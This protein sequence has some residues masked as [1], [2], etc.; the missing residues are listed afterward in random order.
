MK[1]LSVLL[2]SLVLMLGLIAMASASCNV[3]VIIF[4][5]GGENLSGTQNITWSWVNASECINTNSTIDYTVNGSQWIYIGNSTLGSTSFIWNTNS[6]TDNST[7]KIRVNSSNN[8]VSSQDNF[9]VDNTNPTISINDDASTT[10]T[11]SDVINV[12][13]DDSLSGIKETKWIISSD[14]TCDSSKDVDLN[15]SS[16]SGTSVVANDEA[17]YSNKFI[18]F[19]T[20][21]NAGNYNYTVSS[22]I[23]KLDTT[24][25]VIYDVVATPADPSNDNTPTITFKVNDT[26]SGV[27][28][29]T[30]SFNDGNNTFNTSDSKLSCSV[31]TNG[32]NCTMQYSTNLSDGNHTFSINAS[33]NVGIS[34][35]QYQIVNYTVDTIA[36]IGTVT[37]GTPNMYDGDLVQ[38]VNV[39]YNETMDNSTIPVI[40]FS[41]TT[42]TFTFN[43]GV[44][45]S[46][47]KTWTGNFTLTDVNETVAVVTVNSSGAKD[48]AGNLEVAGITTNFSVD[49]QNPVVT[50]VNIS[51][52]LITDVDVNGTV[53]VTVVFNETMDNRT[54]PSLSF[55]SSKANSTLTL[56]STSWSVDNKTFIVV[57]NISDA[58]VEVT[59]VNLTVSEA[60][61]IVGNV[62]NTN[63]T[64][65]L[66]DIDT[67]QPKVDS[68]NVI[69]NP[70]KDGNVSINITFSEA[71]NLSINPNVTVTGL[72]S[73]P[74]IVVGS[75][76]NS[77]VWSGSFILN[78]NNED[79]NATITVASAADV[80]GNTM[81]N[82]NSAGLFAVDTIMPE[83]SAVEVSPNPVRVGTS[84]TITAHVIETHFNGSVAM[85]FDDS[86]HNIKNVTTGVL[87]NGLV[88][89]TVNNLA[90]NGTYEVVVLSNDT[91]RNVESEDEN[92]RATF[93]VIP[94]TDGNPISV[95][96]TL[97]KYVVRPGEI[98]SVNCSVVFTN[99]GHYEINGV[100]N[101]NGVM[102]IV[103]A[104][105]NGSHVVTCKAIDDVNNRFVIQ[106]TSYSV[107]ANNTATGANL[108][109][110][111]ATYGIV[112]IN[113]VKVALDWLYHN[114]NNYYN[115]TQIDEKFSHYYTKSDVYN[116]TESNT[117]FV[118]RNSWTDIDNYPTACANGEY[119]RA[120][121]DTL[122]CVADNDTTYTAGTGLVLTTT[123]FSLDTT[124]TNVLYYL[125][126][127]VDA[128]V[129]SLN[130]SIISETNARTSNDTAL[131]NQITSLENR[132]VDDVPGIQL[133]FTRGWNEFHIPS[134]VLTGTGGVANVSALNL[135]NNY[136]VE[137]VL[138]DINGSYTYISYYDGSNWK[139]YE[140]NG[141]KTFTE[142]PHA[143]NTPDYAYYIYMTS[144][145]TATI[146][147][148]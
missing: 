138:S 79:L 13:V 96:L 51:D 64:S 134:F 110:Y 46:T 130:A 39:T 106:N 140:V 18:C 53:E 115:I 119:V 123:T 48:L 111:I 45:D 16:N 75:F 145:A 12:S 85:I 8:V 30:I 50:S 109:T 147:L 54:N 41:G 29:S 10:W 88:T 71:M 98:I 15:S 9:T 113:N 52:T 36:P 124:Y 24:E 47:N 17:T 80:A 23:Q 114:F 14:A 103:A 62:L 32:Y 142:F 19:R 141:T 74:Y 137:N 56:F 127:Q 38:E 84:F 128:K 82:N 91:A 49:T 11:N 87:S 102:D 148:E 126:S 78:D 125:K 28:N 59:G 131:Q 121:G 73:S 97:N 93:E 90:F 100:Y 21:D 146:D 26:G 60:K 57:Y 95:D 132:V 7:Y 112:S 40:N 33:D 35:N 133:V 66:F 4:P 2:T 6:V 83:T 89:F 107:S 55:S 104:I 120:I 108:I 5:N 27:D 67:K 101:D 136:A 25:P 70:T 42:G 72:N 116:K 118:S 105:T 129:S 61:D 3:S 77:T 31:I 139:I 86:G 135:S 144:P 44:W 94:S 22:K 69:P 65:A 37:V 68:T 143:E 76:Y 20:E 92:N 63:F 58:N 122:T 43:E 34:A 99:H 1:K 117:N 81:K